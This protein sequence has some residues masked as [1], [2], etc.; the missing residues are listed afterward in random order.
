MDSIW[1]FRSSYN[2][3]LRIKLSQ[4]AYCER[5]ESGLWEEIGNDPFPENLRWEMLIDVLRG[6]VKV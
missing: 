4:D 1:S 6:K 5:V 3:A 2:E